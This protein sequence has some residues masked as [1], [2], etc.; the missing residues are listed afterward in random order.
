MAVLQWMSLARI[1]QILSS[2][3]QH[4]LLPTFLPFLPLIFYLL[5]STTYSESASCSDLYWRKGTTRVSSENVNMS[6]Y[7]EIQSYRNMALASTEDL[8]SL[9]WVYFV[10]IMAVVSTAFWIADLCQVKLIRTRQPH[11][12]ESVGPQLITNQLSSTSKWLMRI[13][14]IL[15]L[16]FQKSNTFSDLQECVYLEF[17]KRNLE[18]KCYS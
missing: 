11:H 7:L 2:C 14:T 5:P 3:Q 16:C 12:L 17:K 18:G 4:I 6:M 10:L 15:S 1:A 8:V 13:S 9:L